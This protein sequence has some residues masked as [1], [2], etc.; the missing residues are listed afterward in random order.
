MHKIFIKV[1]LLFSSSLTIMAGATIAPS[2]PQIQQIFSHN[3]QS[4]ILTKLILTVPALFIALFAPI[5]GAAIDR[6]GRL[7]IL[8]SSLILYGFSGTSGFFMND[9][10]SLLVGRAFLGIAVAGIMT[11][12]ITLIADY[13]D[14]LERNAFMGMQG[15]FVAMGGVIFITS[16][17]LLAEISWRAPFLIYLSSFIIFPAALFYLFE[18]DVQRGNRSGRAEVKPDYPKTLVVFIYLTAFLG[19]MLFYII[20]V[21]I[22]FYIKEH[23]GVSNTMIGLA[24]ACSTLSSAIVSL[25]YK[26]IKSLFSFS[27]IYSFAF[28]FLGMGYFIIFLETEYYFIVLGLFI[29]GV[30]MGVLIPNSNVWIVTISPESMRGRIVGG[31]TTA[32]FVGQFISPILVQPILSVTASGVIYAIAGAGMFCISIAFILHNIFSQKEVAY[33]EITTNKKTTA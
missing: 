27:A 32:I 14:G 2:L 28:I 4:E 19:M 1:T 5:A 33:Q 7:R 30:G 15:A 26:R 11:S 21:Q 16:G 22:P 18:P 31:L 20:P 17:G 3:P 6:F 25:N 10:Y 8:L 13:F 12:T 9:L 24:I 29:S 23:T